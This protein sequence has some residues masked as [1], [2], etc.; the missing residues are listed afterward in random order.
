MGISSGIMKIHYVALTI[1]SARGGIEQV[2][3][4]W[5]YTLNNFSDTDT[6]KVSSLYD[7]SYD[8]KYI[9]EK[10]FNAFSASKIKFI[11]KSIL[12]GINSDVNIFSHIHLSIIAVLIRIF[13]P[14][15]K[16]I[17][18]LHGIEVWRELTYIQKLALKISDQLICV[19]DYTKNVVLNKFPELSKKTIVLNNSLDPYYEIGFNSESRIKFREKLSLAYD[20]K[21]II[22]IGRLNSS[23]SYKGYDKVIESLSILENKNVY[24][25]IIG[26]YDSIEYDRVIS[27]INKYKL[28]GR[29]K[30]IGYVNDNTLESYFNAADLFVMPS[31]GEGFGIVYIE[32]MSKGLR[33]LAGNIDGSVDAVKKFS[34]SKLVN[35][36]SISEITSAMKFMLSENFDDKDRFE[37]SKKCMSIFNHKNF[38]DQ[39]INLL[40]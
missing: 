27:I 21:L 29:V 32:S 22:S 1:F 2:S 3:K 17:F 37:L 4:N 23:E 40:K 12:T 35:P 38:S 31:K 25:H 34:E 15:T 16:I 7:S 33:V 28:Q 36:D 11:I 24:Y 8:S 10:K 39:I 14:K 26:K 9:E 30:L 6:I 20:D 5:L 19:S 13:N 18:Q